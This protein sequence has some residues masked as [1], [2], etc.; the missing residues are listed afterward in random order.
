LSVRG[1]VELLTYACPSI[2]LG[3]VSELLGMAISSLSVRGHV[4]LSTYA[5]SQQSMSTY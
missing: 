2:T 5:C 3:Q 1:H 4:E